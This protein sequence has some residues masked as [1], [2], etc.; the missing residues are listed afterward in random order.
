[1]RFLIDECAATELVAAAHAR[2]HEAYHVAYI[3]KSGT[4]DHAL[5]RWAIEDGLIIVTRNAKDFRGSKPPEPGGALG[6]EELHPG[7]VCL[8]VP[9]AN[10]ATQAAA[11]EA[12][13]QYIETLSNMIN[14]VVE[15]YDLG[16][17]W[18]IK[19]YDMPPL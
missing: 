3:G 4:P 18:D 7:L 10:G 15:L 19:R 5:A 14:V 6:K 8:N 16:D 13:L 17:R 2:G 9:D 1:M 12:A 11:F